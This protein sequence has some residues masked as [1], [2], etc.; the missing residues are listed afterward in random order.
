[1]ESAQWAP[2]VGPTTFTF[3]LFISFSLDSSSSLS[4]SLVPFS[5]FSSSTRVPEKK[6]PAAV[7]GA[8]VAWRGAARRGGRE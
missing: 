4:L 2:L 7:P 3:S 1:M 8:A 6:V 5:D